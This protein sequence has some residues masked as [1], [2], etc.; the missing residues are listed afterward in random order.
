MCGSLLEIHCVCS[1]KIKQPTETFVAMLD[2]LSQHTCDPCDRPD[3]WG[4]GGRR[5]GGGAGEECTRG[6]SGYQAVTAC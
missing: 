3:E 2:Q 6:T 4:G 5:W 1:W